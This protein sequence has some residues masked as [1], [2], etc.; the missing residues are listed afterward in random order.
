[1]YFI[2]SKT[3]A[4]LLLPSNLLILAMAIGFVLT[5]TRWRRIGRWLVAMAFVV[6]LVLGYMPVGRA[7]NHVLENR[8]PVWDA[9]RG[10]PDGIVVLGGVI[11]PLRSRLRG[12][13]ALNGAAERATIIAKLARDYPNARIIFTSGDASL[14]GNQGAEA[15]YLSP[16]LDTFGIPRTRVEIENRAR[17]TAENA[18]F[19]KA[20]AKPKP[21]ERWL[22]VT[23]AQHMPRAVGTFRKA[24]FPVEAYPVDWRSVPRFRFAVNDEFGHG[25]TRADDAVHEWLGLFVYWITGRTSEFLPGPATH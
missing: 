6:L 7:L 4:L 20:I 11:D 10:Q 2:L 9:A 12:Q 16:L 17:N 18:A 14:L 19:S 1:M 5:W 22:L 25:I 13:V 8:F 3:V 21:G 15:D 23:S 24:G